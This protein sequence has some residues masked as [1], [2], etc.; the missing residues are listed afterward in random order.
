MVILATGPMKMCFTLSNN[1]AFNMLTSALTAVWL[2]SPPQ[3]NKKAA[4]LLPSHL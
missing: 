4:Q 3:L 1:N 2:C